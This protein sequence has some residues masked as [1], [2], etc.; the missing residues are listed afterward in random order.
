MCIGILATLWAKAAFAA[1]S[2]GLRTVYRIGLY[3]PE[4]QAQ[5][6]MGTNA[7]FEWVSLLFA[8]ALHSISRAVPG[9]SNRYAH[10][11]IVALLVVGLSI[12]LLGFTVAVVVPAGILWY[13]IATGPPPWSLLLALVGVCAS[14]VF[15]AAVWHVG[16]RTLV[17]A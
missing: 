2:I 15:L 3:R 12:F 8:R 1:L 17:S 4:P 16:K 9:D 6:E 7:A 5:R 10:T 11:W 13:V 14:F